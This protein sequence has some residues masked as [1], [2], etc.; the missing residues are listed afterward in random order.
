MV[1]Q[2][3]VVN[4]ELVAILTKGTLMDAEMLQ[5]TPDAS[6][7]LAGEQGCLALGF[8]MKQAYL[9]GRG[10][11]VCCMLDKGA[12][13]WSVHFSGA[14]AQYCLACIRLPHG[15]CLP[16]P[17]VT[18]ELVEDARAA[19]ATQH[20]HSAKRIRFGACAVDVATGRMLL[21]QW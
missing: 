20:G 6:Y 3:K 16:T 8:G 19:D 1:V 2:V 9:F 17:A 4:R 21:G 7:L 15:T 14:V 10:A 13:C 18:E 5:T 11:C 12:L